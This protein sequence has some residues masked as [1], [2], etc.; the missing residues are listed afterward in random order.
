VPT[1]ILDDLAAEYRQLDAMLG[2]LS[3]DQWRQPSAC[4]GWSVAD[5]VLHLAQ[6]EEAVAGTAGGGLGLGGWQGVGDTVDAAM[7]ALV[8]AQRGDPAET[9][10]RWRQ[11]SQAA[12]A[13]LRS[14]DPQQPLNWVTNQLK[15]ATLATTRLAE[16][17][18]HAQ[19]IAGP[20]GLDYPDTARLRHIAWLGYHTLPYSFRLDGE[21]APTVYC[22]LS[23]PDGSVWR[24][25]PAD[26]DSSIT[27]SASAFCRV[28]AR[29]LAAEESGLTTTGPSGLSALRRLRNYAER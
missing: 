15:P 24:F 9:Y 22:E 6:S 21:E 18:A 1:E 28:G 11:A 5:V 8:S 23:G 20:L 16:H 12:V 3:A 27:G 2:A 25:G 17:W 29:R 19:D 14:V 26:A 10:Q 4:D 13:A 7:D